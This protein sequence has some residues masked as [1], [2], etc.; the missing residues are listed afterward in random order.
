M[1]KDEKRPEQTTRRG[2]AE[3][4]AQPFQLF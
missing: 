3:S 2:I 4:N 1:L